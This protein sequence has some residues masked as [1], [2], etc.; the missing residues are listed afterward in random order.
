MIGKK[1]LLLA[2]GLVLPAAVA[3][4]G[5]G[6]QE[7]VPSERTRSLR[8][9]LDGATRMRVRSGGTCHRNPEI[10]KSLCETT[11]AAAIASLVRHIEIRDEES[12]FECMC[13]GNP[14]L[15]FYRGNEL[16]VT[17][18]Y[19]HGTSLRWPDG[20][21]E[22][23]GLLAPDGAKFL[24]GW[25]ADRGVD[26]PKKER[27]EEEGRYEKSVR[28]REKWLGAMPGSLKPFWPRMAD[29]FD[30]PDPDEM[31]K[32]LAAQFGDRNERILALLKWYGSGEGPWSGF[33]S[34]EGEAEKLLLR[35]GTEE[36]LGA[37]EG[38]ALDPE[39]LEG[40]ARLFAGREFGRRPGD[41]RLLPASLK[42]RLLEHCMAS[43]D[44]DKRER[45]KRAFE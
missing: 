41:P 7:S 18:G 3:G 43:P 35:H 45:A 38:R 15:E 11:D 31:H 24:N 39:R 34:Y 40:T 14:A 4:Y 42:R 26:G 25:L 27:E 37:I 29:P 32:A 33:P 23:D 28:S 44:A 22:G 13:C 19:H 10:E 8:S 12:G 9:A 21:W 16:A 2:I 6:G 20:K 5:F 17:L 30:L 1:R 36:I